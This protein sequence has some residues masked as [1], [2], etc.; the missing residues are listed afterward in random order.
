MCTR[1]LPSASDD[2]PRET[3]MHPK[4]VRDPHARRPKVKD[5]QLDS[6]IKQAWGAGWWAEKRLTGHVMCYHPDLV[7][8][9]LVNNTAG[10]RHVVRNVRNFF[11]KAGLNL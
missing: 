11:R 9:V 7:E 8:K 5:K 4:R 10:D 1:I 2:T 3:E 6:M